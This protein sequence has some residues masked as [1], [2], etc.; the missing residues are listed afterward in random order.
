MAPRLAYA[1]VGAEPP[2]GDI[3]A[4][5]GLEE[6]RPAVK[7]AFNTLLCDTHQRKRGW[8]TPKEGNAVLPA[9]WTVSRFRK[10]LL[11][12]HPRLQPCLGTGMAHR[13]QNIE[14]T[15]LVEVLT[16]LKARRIPALSIHDAVMVA[17]SRANEVKVVM[18]E[19]AFDITSANIPVDV[20]PLHPAR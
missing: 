1:L 15:I 6:H 4:L 7:K 2:A 11:A 20:K 10:A 13:S 3:Y 14:S 17:G 16:E 18:E 12:R 19:A 9:T 5:P 8:P